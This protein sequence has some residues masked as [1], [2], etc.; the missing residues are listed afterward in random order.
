M[1][2]FVLKTTLSFIFLFRRSWLTVCAN[3]IPIAFSHWL[4]TL[5]LWSVRLLHALNF[6]PNSVWYRGPCAVRSGLNTREWR[7][8]HVHVTL[9][10]H[11]HFWV[12]PTHFS[13]TLGFHH[14]K[15][16]EL[17]KNAG[18]VQRRLEVSE[19]KEHPAFLAGMLN[20]ISK[21]RE[22]F[23]FVLRHQ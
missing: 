17:L 15:S 9:P 5:P 2:N 7:Q 23:L 8:E 18:F 14:Q 10:G 12:S 22:Q 19:S 6:C 16:Q 1:L 13:G 3:R 11:P 20:P 4:D 21:V